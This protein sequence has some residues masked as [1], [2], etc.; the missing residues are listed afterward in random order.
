MFLAKYQLLVKPILTTSFERGV[1][2]FIS[3]CLRTFLLQAVFEP[4]FI[5]VYNLVYTALPVM[6]LGF[7]DKV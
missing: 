7:L 6:A 2:I 1:E 4:S 3:L 5:G